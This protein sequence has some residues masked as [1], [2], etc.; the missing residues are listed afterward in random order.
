MFAGHAPARYA[1]R[2][3]IC[4]VLGLFVGEWWVYHITCVPELGWALLFNALWA[5]AVWSYV[6]T[7]LTD[8]GT[9]ASPEWE[10]WAA[11]RGHG[12]TQAQEPMDKDGS[13]APRRGSSRRPRGW[14]PGEVTWCPECLRDR[15]ERA[16]HCSQ[17][18]LC[19]L[20]MDHHCPWVGNC[21]GWRNHK[22]FLLLT[23]RTSWTCFAWLTTLHGPSVSEAMD[24]FAR[25][26]STASLVPCIGTVIAAVFLLITGC[27]F[28]YSFGSV[29]RN[30]TTVEE[31]CIGEN[32]YAL[33]SCLDNLKQL[34]GP[35]DWRLLFP[36]PPEGRLSGTDYPIAP[37]DGGYGAC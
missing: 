15:P 12:Y 10:V 1:A 20:R 21:I 32:P 29:L 34:M 25:E 14:R 26:G 18:G 28:F 16:H 33:P 4:V 23:W 3:T 13:D 8:P 24:V 36:L 31:L 37:K 30:L 22:H 6:Q 9:P 27:I 7:S 2:G 35:V 11:G 5:L 17:C 19:I